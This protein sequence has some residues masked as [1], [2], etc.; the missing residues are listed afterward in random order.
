MGGMLLPAAFQGTE[1]RG[2][3]EGSVNMTG[4]TSDHFVWIQ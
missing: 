2:T 4:T 1:Q 3:V